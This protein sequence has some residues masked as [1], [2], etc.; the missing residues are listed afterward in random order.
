MAGFRKIRHLLFAAAFGA[1]SLSVPATGAPHTDF[2]GNYV[3]NQG[4]G[5]VEIKQ[6]DSDISIERV[7]EG[8]ADNNDVRLDGKLQPCLTPSGAPS[9][10][11]AQWAGDALTLHF[12]SRETTGPRQ[13]PIQ[14]HT[15]ERLSLSKN[16]VVLTIRIE[17]DAPLNPGNPTA[18]QQ[19]F[20][21]ETYTRE[22]N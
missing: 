12:Y 20:Q 22:Q 16:Q 7:V 17:V 9:T 5:H 11:R 18:S 13:P 15:L 14:V 3:L 21:M 10:C 4:V 6:T 2:S 19:P 8:R 1:L